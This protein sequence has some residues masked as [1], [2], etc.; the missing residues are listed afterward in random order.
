MGAFGIILET[1]DGTVI[2]TSSANYRDRDYWAHLIHK[3]GT[4]EEIR[5]RELPTIQEE[6]PRLQKAI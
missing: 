5:E 1:E 6:L 3:D 4:H 2:W